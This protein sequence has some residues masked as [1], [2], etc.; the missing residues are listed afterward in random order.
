VSVRA[1][2]SD[3]RRVAA[4]IRFLEQHADAQPSLTRLAAHLGLSEYHLHRLFKRWAGVTPKD[5]V[6][7]LTLVRAKRL[8]AEAKSVLETSLEVGLSGPARLHDLFVTLEAMTPGD[9]KERGK[10]LVVRW[11]RV[12]TPFGPA[13]FAATERGLCALSFGGGPRELAARWPGATLVES[14]RSLAPFAAAACARM[15]GEATEPLTLVARG[16]SFQLKIW[17][18]LLALPEGAVTSYGELAAAVGEPGASRAAGTAVGANPIAVLIPCHRVLRATG[19]LGDYRWGQERKC[20][21]LASQGARRR[22][23]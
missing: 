5:F 3:Y 13:L 8:L 6:Q 12:E 7:M 14:P 9:Y 16:T 23:T 15:R 1:K 21:L 17:A 18:A 2:G 19:V 20:A 22:A 10:G 4:A 11:A